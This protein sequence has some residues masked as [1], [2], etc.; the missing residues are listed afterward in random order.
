MSNTPTNMQTPYI[1]ETR[2]MHATQLDIFSRLMSDRI[3]FLGGEVTADAA[4]IIQGQLLF[5]DN[6]NHDPITLFINS[7]GGSVYAGLGIY[8]TMRHIKSP[9][10]TICTSMAMSM[11]A[12]LLIG[13]EKGHRAC[14]PHGT[15]MI[16]QP[17]SQFDY[18]KF[19][20]HEIQLKEMSRLKDILYEC[21]AKDSGNTVEDI[22]SWCRD[23]FY[24]SP[25]KAL[26]LGF[27]D[28][29]AEPEE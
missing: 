15:I 13:G 5:L 7:P 28:K 12:V 21:M 4:N 20:S 9:V 24:M 2:D 3:I 18:A 25:E 16:H 10:H 14:L 22:E 8:D 19:T 26:E 11:G 17:S 27:I 23:D 1:L 29:I 6:L